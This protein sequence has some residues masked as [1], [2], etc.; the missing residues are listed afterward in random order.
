MV[1]KCRAALSFETCLCPA[2][3][4]A[5][6]QNTLAPGNARASTQF[7]N[8]LFPFI[9]SASHISSRRTWRGA[10][11]NMSIP[12]VMISLREC[13]QSPANEK[14]SLPLPRHLHTEKALRGRHL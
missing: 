3:Y 8:Y 6:G 9:H 7:A 12:G 1:A 5:A 10:G 13:P 11:R 14:P 4:F 2:P